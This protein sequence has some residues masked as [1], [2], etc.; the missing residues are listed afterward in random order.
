[1]TAR[2]ARADD[3][4]RTRS[5]SILTARKTKTQVRVGVTAT[6]SRRVTPAQNRRHV[7][8]NRRRRHVVISRRRHHHVVRS[9]HRHDIRS[10][11]A[12][13][14][15]KVVTAIA[16]LRAKAQR[17]IHRELKAKRK[18]TKPVNL[19][20]ERTRAIQI[21]PA[22]KLHSGDVVD[23]HRG[24]VGACGRADRGSARWRPPAGQPADLIQ[25]IQTTVFFDA[26]PRCG[27]MKALLPAEH[28]FD[29]PP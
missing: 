9:S 26:D 7:A 22:S 11:A 12:A 1:M 4:R 2:V 8:I 24:R 15:T 29:R 10:R 16:N 21:G 13:S 20:K 18:M 19:Q 28:R 27:T 23:R 6:R 25:L 3:T 5:R 14:T 17:K